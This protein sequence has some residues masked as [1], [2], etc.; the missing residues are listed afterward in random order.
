M[1]FKEN[2]IWVADI[3][4][5]S[6]KIIQ[7]KRKSDD[8]LEIVRTFRKKSLT[9]DAFFSAPRKEDFEVLADCLT[10]YRRGDQITIL[11]KDPAVII[12][13]F[14]IKA[15]SEQSLEDIVY[16][17]MKKLSAETQKKWHY[18]YVAGQRLEVFEQLGLEERHFDVVGIYAEKEL[19]KTCQKLFKA[20]DY[21][22]TK[23]IPQFLGLGK[24]LE[25]Q[26]IKNA[27]LVDLGSSQVTIYQYY[28][29]VL[30]HQAKLAIDPS[31]SHEENLANISNSI[32]NQIRLYQDKRERER[33][34]LYLIGGGALNP[35]VRNYFMDHEKWELAD[36]CQLIKEDLWNHQDLAQ[37]SVSLFFTAMAGLLV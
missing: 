9:K 13:P 15:V 30:R 12:E 29:G 28:E 18:D 1:P 33:S 8:T 37:E 32:E 31:R 19:I 14:M 17:K 25:K 27:L 11:L 35:G 24:I 3:G 2:H 26:G 21:R 22:V 10:D 34:Q 36:L 4:E 23:I 5:A 20:G 6:V 16:W 7:A